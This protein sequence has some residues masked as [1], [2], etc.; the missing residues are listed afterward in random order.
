MRQRPAEAI[1]FPDNQT[2]AWPEEGERFCKTRAIVLAAADVIVEQL[3]LID[4]GGK[5]R[6]ALKV[7]HLAVI[8]GG[9]AHIADQHV[10]KPIRSRFRILSHSDMSF[11]AYFRP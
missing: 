6:V 8:V 5:K 3:A 2:I 11:R 4:P 1:Q 7:Q 10:R 9:N